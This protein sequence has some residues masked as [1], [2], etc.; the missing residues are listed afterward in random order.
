MLKVWKKHKQVIRNFFLKLQILEEVNF[1]VICAW[2]M[3]KGSQI[4]L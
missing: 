3:G 4:K 1:L 2:I